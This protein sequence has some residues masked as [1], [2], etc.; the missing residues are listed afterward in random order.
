VLATAENT[1]RTSGDPTAH[2]ETNLVREV[3]G[4]LSREQL[5]GTTLYASTEPCAMCAGAV[6]FSG[7]GAVV[8]AL[9]AQDLGAFTGDSGGFLLELP[10]RE[11][12]A[13]GSRPVLVHGPVDLPEARAV[14]EGAWSSGTPSGPP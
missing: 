13:A 3:A 8:Y 11:V 1:A 6:F 7:I 14:H 4:R 12:F 10:C 5:A 2:A 9:A